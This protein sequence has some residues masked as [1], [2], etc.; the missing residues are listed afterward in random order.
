MSS[1][2]PAR[3]S[4]PTGG[5]RPGWLR[6]AVVGAALVVVVAL[7]LILRPA[8]GAPDPG[9]GTTAGEGTPGP[10][11]TASPGVS[12]SP[13]AGEPTD[14]ATATPEPSEPGVSAAPSEEGDPA[15]PAD[16]ADPDARPTAAPVPLDEE[17]EP[18][19]EVEVG[20]AR[21]EAVQGEAN[22]PGEVGGPSLRVTVS[23]VNGTASELALSS[24]VV[25]LY[26]GSDQAPA[27]ELLEPGRSEFP[28]TV[29]PGEEAT[30][31]FV[32]LVPE[33][34]RDQVVIEFDLSA[35]A[36]VLLFSGPVEV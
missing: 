33:D 21:I 10:S 29:G 31:V 17:A 26:H 7:V 27:I 34:R 32:F 5:T 24:A 9:D 2:S 3:P 30:G 15:D 13:S 25:N 4:S 19:A 35:D 1:P 11:T 23:V 8:A 18:T 28:A 14:P 16:P 22:V 12:P 36:T 20:V 6:W